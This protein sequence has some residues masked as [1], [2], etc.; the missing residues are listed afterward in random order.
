MDGRT[1]AFPIQRQARD[2]AEIAMASRR[3]RMIHQRIAIFTALP[4]R[5]LR[6]LRPATAAQGIGGSIRAK[7]KAKEPR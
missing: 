2:P 7:A 6:R 5:S 4:I 3:L 1:G